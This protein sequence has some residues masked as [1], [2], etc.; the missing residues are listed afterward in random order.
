MAKKK[1][2]AFP[3][4]RDLTERKMTS[5]GAKLDKLVDPNGHKHWDALFKA[6]DG[7]AA[8][9]L[10]HLVRCGL[11]AQAPQSAGLVR[12][13]GEGVSYAKSVAEIVGV[14]RNFPEDMG[15]MDRGRARE[16]HML[17]PGVL[18]DVDAMIVAAYLMDRDALVA[19]Q[20]ELST[21]MRLAIDMVRRRA[22]E[23]I[24]PASSRAIFDH[25]VRAHCTSYGLASNCDIPRIV[26]GAEVECRLADDAAVKD[27]ALLFGNE[28]AWAEGMAAWLRPRVA[29]FRAETDSLAKRAGDGLRLLP[30]SE[31]I[32]LFGDGWWNPGVLIE[33]IDGRGDRPAELLAAAATL[34]AEGTRPFKIDVAQLPE[35][36]GSSDNGGH[37]DDDDDDDERDDDG[38]DE[39]R[40]DDEYFD[41]YED[42]GE[43]DPDEPE[44]DPLD[45]EADN[46]RVRAL[47]EVLT[48]VA[49]DRLAAA[50]EA[51]PAEIDDTF[52]LDRVFESEPIYTLRLRRALAALGPARA[53]AIIRRIAAKDYYFGKA[54][55]ICDVCYEPAVVEHVLDKIDAGDYGIDAGL[56]GLCSPKVV[57]HA[58]AHAARQADPKR[59]GKYR[60]GILY[61]LARAAAAGEGW[62][63]ALDPEISMADIYFAYGG[64]KVTPVLEM[65]RALPLPRY[66]AILEANLERCADE[67]W[68]LVRCLRADLPE[69]A[70]ETV[71]KALVARPKEVSGG[72]LGDDLRALGGVI[73]DPLR[74]AIGDT[75]LP[76]T[77]MR[78]L[79][80][81]MDNA[82]YKALS[83]ALD[84]PVE[85]PRE[86]LRRLA[87]EQPGPKVRIYLLRRAERAP[88]EGEVGRA[89]GAAIGAP[90]SAIPARRGEAMTHVLTLDLAAMPELA[91]RHPGVRALALFLPDPEYGEHHED[92]VLMPIP[93]EALAEAAAAPADEDAAAILVEGFDVPAVIFGG[94]CEGDLKRIRGLVYQ[95][96]GY[97]LGGPLWLQDGDPGLDPSF[98]GQFD[99]SLAYINLGDMGVMYLFEG[100][101]T[102]QC[103]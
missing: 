14:L 38:Y 54:A 80:R 36:E 74:R 31:V 96:S 86:E 30:L 20:G 27:L 62:D 40:D 34:R 60:E 56:L 94:S 35:D 77:F 76:G 66:Q 73:V 83:E 3:L 37:D 100:W 58:A 95:A 75:Q 72:K 39:E 89:G 7:I 21:N 48:V 46:E 88:A 42:D 103:H 45:A 1:E 82:A 24:D 78:E 64:S 65:L 53:H 6:S 87:A 57:P 2:P 43:A 17:T 99:E 8:E 92:G 63:P 44:E 19:A 9:L 11:V 33:V 55:A 90:A 102:W 79:E 18:Q 59:A 98:V 69:A 26:D 16:F 41:D 97:C 4:Y 49:I 84:R 51:L 71:F 12:M 29:K 70:L 52:E 10:W 85:T 68:R 101:I 23:A 61:V 28:G 91:A 15:T 47:A 13:L 81:A 67:P 50:G 25:L 32:Y 22:G 5:L 93:S